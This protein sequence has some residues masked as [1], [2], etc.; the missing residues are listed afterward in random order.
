MNR[1]GD[2]SSEVTDTTQELDFEHA[3][4]GEAAERTDMGP[5][6]C[7]IC[8]GPISD[9]YFT[10]DGSFVCDRCEGPARV[11]G[12]SGSSFT[13]LL[14]AMAAGT[15]A[16][17]IASALWMTVTELTGYEIGLIAIAVGWIVGIAIQVGNRGVGGVPYQLMAVFLTYSAIV[18]TYVPM[19][20]T[21]FEASWTEPSSQSVAEA[22]DAA[23]LELGQADATEDVPMSAEDAQVAAWVVAIPFAYAI[24]F[25][26][27]FENA[28]GMLIIGFALYQAWKMTVKHQFQWAGPFR[29]GSAGAE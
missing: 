9:A 5:L 2:A 4:Y 19:L 28:I 17:I 26:G 1:G 15:F 3:D 22:N 23:V 29:V 18:M 12:P 16:A 7:S 11:A 20:V 27:G 14:G 10:R 21:E 25:L 24:P 13:R 8:E 6:S